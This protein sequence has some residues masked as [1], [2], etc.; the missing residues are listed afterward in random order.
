MDEEIGGISGGIYPGKAEKQ[1]YQYV[2]VC[3]RLR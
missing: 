3:N 2:D 1:I